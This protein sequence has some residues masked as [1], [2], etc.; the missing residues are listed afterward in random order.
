MSVPVS[1]RRPKLQRDWTEQTSVR[2]PAFYFFAFQ[3]DT[4]Q[5]VDS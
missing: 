2:E 5:T 1:G 3:L 4:R